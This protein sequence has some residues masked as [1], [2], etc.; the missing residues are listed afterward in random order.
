MHP[1][2]ALVEAAVR[3]A[4]GLAGAQVEI[5]LR[6]PLTYQSNLLYDVWAGGRHWIGKA[7][8][9]A[10]E[11]QD[12]PRREYQALCRL[13]ELDLAPQ[14]I[15]YDPALG[16]VVLYEYLE[17][18]MWDRRCP[19][20]AELESLAQTW[21]RIH[22]VPVDWPARTQRHSL[23]QAVA[24]FAG[25]FHAYAEWA[26]SA[27]A[28]GL[29]AVRVCLQ[30]LE[31]RQ[32]E[33]ARLSGLPVRMCFCRS[34]PRFA[35]IIA[36]P[37][38]RLGLVDWEDS[39]LSDPARELAD[40]LTHSNQEDLLSRQEWQAFTEPYLRTLCVQDPALEERFYLYQGIFPLFWLSILLSYGLR[41]QQNAQQSAEM[42]A[43]LINEMPA[44]ER[45]QRCLGRAYA[46]P[47]TLGA[48]HL[49]WAGEF[50][51]FP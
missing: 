41:R 11:Q 50:R 20:A 16:P 3:A 37:D 23:Q 28:P 19:T 35:N 5:A 22:A 33:I 46:W 2:Q 36:R 12:A 15:F 44:R 49:A 45:L 40:L 4:D 42:S 21:L 39:G 7:Y 31:Q 8:L 1:S 32:A 25:R 34:D 29:Q 18:V 47:E 38:G 13:Q 27:F 9:R 10:D 24:L 48:E 14:P 43:W 51:F 17:G 30:L 6:P 26:Q